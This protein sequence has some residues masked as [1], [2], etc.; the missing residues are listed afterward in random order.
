MHYPKSGV[1]PNQFVVHKKYLTRVE[2]ISCAQKTNYPRDVPIT[3]V[4]ESWNDVRILVQ[5]LVY[6]SSY[7]ESSVLASITDCVTQS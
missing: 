3:E 6:P 5:A 2:S 7:L 4:T 1:F